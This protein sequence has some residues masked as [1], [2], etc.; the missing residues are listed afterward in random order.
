MA[1]EHY[2]KIMLSPS[3]LALILRIA[4]CSV[5]VWPL[6]F[7]SRVFH[8]I[9]FSSVARPSLKARG[10]T[11]ERTLAITTVRTRAFVPSSPITNPAA[12][13]SSQ[14]IQF[15]EHS[16]NS[17]RHR[18]HVS[19]TAAKRCQTATKRQ[20]VSL[21]TRFLICMFGMSGIS[22][23]CLLTKTRIDIFMSC[24]TPSFWKVSQMFPFI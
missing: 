10:A 24:F 9:A 19:G 18:Q 5:C 12:S 4:A 6:F 14:S 15:P 20:I 7:S 8:L 16:H 11:R 1:S 2:T 13:R 21:W 22:F 23:E 3:V 17:I